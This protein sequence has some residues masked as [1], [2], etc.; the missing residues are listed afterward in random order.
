VQ[1]SAGSDAF[2]IEDNLT[3][4]TANVVIVGGASDTIGRLGFFN[5]NVRIGRTGGSGLEFRTG[6]ASVAMTIDSLQSVGIGEVSPTARLHIKGSGSTSA[7]TALLV[8]NSAGTE[9]LKVTDDSV[10]NARGSLNVLHP[11][12]V[13]RSLRLGWGSIFATDSNSELSIG[14]VCSVPSSPQILLAGNTRG[15]G[16][17]TMQLQASAGVSVASSVTNPNASAQLDVSSTTKGFLPPRMTTTQKNA[18][19][20][21]ASGLQVYD[22]TLNQM[23]Y[24]NGTTWVNI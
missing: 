23:S 24:Y 7:T 18:I 21:P 19:S 8:Q 20:S 17:N 15:S 5:E 12:I 10:T 4:K 16:A 13:T 3:I 14:A 6:S 22:T 2:K 11:T 9:V 1:N